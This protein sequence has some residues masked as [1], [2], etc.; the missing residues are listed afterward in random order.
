MLEI[1][2]TEPPDEGTCP[3]CGHDL[4][5]ATDIPD[6]MLCDVCGWSRSGV[7]R[8]IRCGGRDDLV[9]DEAVCAKCRK[10]G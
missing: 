9:P 6:D 4:A 8:C 7:R 5:E 2:E 10:G 1:E 3:R